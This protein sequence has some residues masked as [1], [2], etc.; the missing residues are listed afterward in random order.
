MDTIA[1]KAEVQLRETGKCNLDKRRGAQTA[2][3]CLRSGIS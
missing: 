2:V 3:I 1:W